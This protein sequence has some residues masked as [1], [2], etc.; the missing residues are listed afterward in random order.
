MRNTLGQAVKAIYAGLVGGLGALGALLVNDTS[1]GDIT[2][3]Q[4]VYVVT[5]ALVLGGGVYGL[6]NAEPPA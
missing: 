2:A 4:W 1:L 3:G 5:T 6:K